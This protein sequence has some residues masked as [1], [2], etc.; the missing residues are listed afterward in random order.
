[1]PRFYQKIT[2]TSMYKLHQR[3]LPLD[4]TRI[5]LKTCCNC[6]GVIQTVCLHKKDPHDEEILYLVPRSNCRSKRKI[7]KKK[8]KGKKAW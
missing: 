1:M 6:T 2:F 4:P 8:N 3:S 5:I 7:V